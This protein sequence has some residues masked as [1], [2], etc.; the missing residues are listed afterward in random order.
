MARKTGAMILMIFMIVNLFS[1]VN[2][3]TFCCHYDM[4]GI[5][6]PL[7]AMEEYKTTLFSG[8]IFQ[9]WLVQTL[10]VCIACSLIGILSMCFAMVVKEE[11][12]AMLLGVLV[13]IIFIVL[14]FQSLCLGNPV[15]LLAGTN[16][17][18]D[19]DLYW[20]VLGTTLGLT[21]LCAGGLIWVSGKYSVSVHG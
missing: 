9:Y 6:E 1:I 12:Y 20:Y 17:I 16:L 19:M 7:Y 14:F 5:H 2:L 18:K 4:E 10:G 8:T 21:L 3:C 11:L 13:Y 15:G